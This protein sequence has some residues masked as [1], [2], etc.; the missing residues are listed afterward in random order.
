MSLDPSPGPVAAQASEIREVFF[1][2]ADADAAHVVRDRHPGHMVAF[3]FVEPDGSTVGLTFGEL[4][5]RSPRSPPAP[6]QR[7]A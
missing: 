2:A 5:G 3:T 4:R 6:G 7:T 1:S